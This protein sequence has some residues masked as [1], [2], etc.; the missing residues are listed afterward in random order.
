LGHLLARSGDAAGAIEHLQLAV[1]AAPAW[2]EAWINLA[3]ELAIQARFTEAREAAAMALRL[4]PENA[5]AQR[6]SDQLGRDP[7]ARQDPQ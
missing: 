2:T 4:D 5:K 7:R 6:L 3:A 1:R